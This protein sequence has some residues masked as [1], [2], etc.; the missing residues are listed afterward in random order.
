MLRLRPDRRGGQRCDCGEP[1]W[2]DADAAGV[3]W[4]ARDG[5]WAFADLLPVAR[6]ADG[7]A[8]AAGGRRWC[9]L[10]TSTSTAR[11]ST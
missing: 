9:E 2:F 3:D 1:L 5:V 7:L 10:P 6:P 4:P 8:A 11:E